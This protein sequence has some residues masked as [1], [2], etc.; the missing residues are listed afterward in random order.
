MTD[1]EIYKQALK[2]Y[3]Y[4]CEL[5]N[6]KDFKEC[7]EIC[8]RYNFDFFHDDEELFDLNFGVGCWTI[9]NEEGKGKVNE[10]GIELW[11]DENCD[12]LGDYSLE[13][14]RGNIEQ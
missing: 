8:K 3:E 10:N 9:N 6:G 2:G 4:L 14:I 1:Q 13:E 12:C 11:N 7:I 5:F